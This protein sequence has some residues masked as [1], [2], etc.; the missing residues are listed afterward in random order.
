MKRVL[1]RGGLVGGYT[2]KRTAEYDFA[3][4]WPMLRGAEAVGGAALHSA[5]V[6]EGSIDGMCASLEA[7]GFTDVAATEIEVAQT[8][9][10]FDDYWQS[11]THPSSPSG[12]TVAALDPSQRARLRDLLRETM[13]A[14][15]GTITYSS[16]AIAGKGRKP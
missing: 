4:Y 15:D 13:P 5:V 12:K 11:Q 6:P 16:I 2:W 9:I 14:A 1:T 3:A 10:S 7:A 8:Y